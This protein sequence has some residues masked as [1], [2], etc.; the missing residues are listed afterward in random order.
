MEQ[1]TSNYQER[2]TTLPL[3]VKN[4]ANFLTLRKQK[5]ET[6]H[7]QLVLSRT[8]ENISSFSKGYYNPFNFKK[9][10]ELNNAAGITKNA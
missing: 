9:P 2:W 1:H 4:T 6:T 8:L 7:A 10:K 5:Y 3:S